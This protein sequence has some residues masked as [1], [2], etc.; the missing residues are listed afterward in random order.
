[1]AKM[2]KVTDRKAF[3]VEGILLGEEQTPCV[4]VRQ[5]YTT[6]KAPKDWKPGKNGFVIPVENAGRLAKAI[7]LTSQ[8]DT[9]SFK[10]LSQE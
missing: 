5:M 4:S 8:E 6:V 1:M 2:V 7:G 9:S 3:R 10:D